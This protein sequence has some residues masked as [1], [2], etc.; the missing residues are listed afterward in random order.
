MEETLDYSCGVIRAQL[1][2]TQKVLVQD[3][4]LRLGPGET[5]A[6]VGETGSGKT[7]LAQSLM[8]VLPPNVHRHGGKIFICGKEIVHEKQLR[9]M[10][11]KE[12]VYIP[13]NGYEFLNPTRTVRKHLYDSLARIA[14]PAGK[15]AT[16]ALEKLEQA[17]F[18]EPKSVIDRYPFE[19]SG[20]MAQR[21]TIALALCSRAKLLI[22]DEPTNGL[23]ETAK[24][25]FMH[26]LGTLFPEAGKLVVTH[27]ISVAAMCDRLLV[28]C[29]GRAME[30]GKATDV[31]TSPYHPYTKSLLASLVEN[32][33]RQTPVLRKEPGLCPFYRRCN[34]ATVQ[35][36]K[37]LPKQEA[38]GREWWCYVK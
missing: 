9:A 30:T 8:G 37:K 32:G 25:R 29:R 3:V 10:L 38:D 16:V 23:D 21:V 11:G 20:G 24:A 26:L 35:C 28:L 31:L 22:A 1:D 14:V 7:I 17:G 33:M 36:Q 19:L 27:D 2:R 5:L 34:Q 4:V 13:Q 12:I 18:S 15:R 6:L